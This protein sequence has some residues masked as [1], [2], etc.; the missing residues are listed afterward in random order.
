MLT[1]FAA[2][3]CRYISPATGRRVIYELRLRV[4]GHTV[5]DEYLADAAI[6]DCDVRVAAL[7]RELND[8]FRPLEQA[9]GVFVEVQDV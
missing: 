9:E 6:Q 1:R 8:S 5:T 4:T 7:A 2:V 3:V